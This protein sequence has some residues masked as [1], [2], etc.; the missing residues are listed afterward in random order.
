ME[1]ISKHIQRAFSVQTIAQIFFSAECELRAAVR[2]NAQG[3]VSAFNGNSSVQHA[4]NSGLSVCARKGSQG[5]N[6]NEG[7]LIIMGNY[8]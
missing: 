1:H 3:A 4:R 8:C 5:C 6:C 2:A 7:C